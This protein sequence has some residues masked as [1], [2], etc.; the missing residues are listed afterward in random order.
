MLLWNPAGTRD[1]LV[2][3]HH[4]L[5][6]LGLEFAADLCELAPLGLCR[7][8]IEGGKGGAD[9]GRGQGGVED[10]GPRS[11]DQIVDDGGVGSDEPAHN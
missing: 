3:L 6:D 4:E 9:A 11:I 2:G 7:N 8:Q 10:E 5:L 1:Y